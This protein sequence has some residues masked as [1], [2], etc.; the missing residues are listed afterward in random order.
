MRKTYQD[1]ASLCCARKHTDLHQKK[2]VSRIDAAEETEYGQE[3]H[4][5]E[6]LNRKVPADASVLNHLPS[7]RNAGG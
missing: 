1:R 6:L 2:Q 5:Y 7:G 3:T 4:V